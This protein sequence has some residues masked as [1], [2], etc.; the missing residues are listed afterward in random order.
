MLY[1]YLLKTFI[2]LEYVVWFYEFDELV[3][4]VTYTYIHFVT[5][6]QENPKDRDLAK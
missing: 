6:I 5:P 2:F 3:N 1:V 4:L